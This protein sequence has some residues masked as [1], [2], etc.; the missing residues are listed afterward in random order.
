MAGASSKTVQFHWLCTSREIIVLLLLSYR[1]EGSQRAS[2]IAQADGQFAKNLACLTVCLQAAGLEA[3]KSMH[4]FHF[5]YHT[6]RLT[7]ET[8]SNYRTSHIGIIQES[9]VYLAT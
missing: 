4:A 6:H 7:T 8:I 1:P 9:E 5:R 2:V 3:A